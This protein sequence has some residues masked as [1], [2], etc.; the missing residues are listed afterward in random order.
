MGE[1][2][3]RACPPLPR[4]CTQRALP[5][6]LLKDPLRRRSTHTTCLVQGGPGRGSCPLRG[7]ASSRRSRVQGVSGGVLPHRF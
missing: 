6:Y 1:E 2:A 3:A 7:R 4:T 5:R